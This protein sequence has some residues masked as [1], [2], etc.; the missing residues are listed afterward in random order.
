VQY[1][2]DAALTEQSLNSLRG[3]GLV[4]RRQSSHLSATAA[5]EPR[6]L[7]RP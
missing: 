5:G 2:L 4:D 1:P 7:V 3:R 6:T